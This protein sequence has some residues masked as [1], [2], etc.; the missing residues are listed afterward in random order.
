MD[1]GNPKVTVSSSD[2]AEDR[3]SR[4]ELIGWWNQDILGRAKV[5]VVGAGA[6]GNEILKNLA[7][8]G[9]EHIVV[10]D[11]DI[12][13]MSNLSRSVLFREEDIGR[14]KAEVAAKRV[15]ELYPQCRIKAIAANVMYDVGMGLVGWADVVIGALDNREARLW[16]N[17]SAWKMN[18]PWVDGAIEGINGVV[19]VFMPGCAPCYE[20]TLGERDWDILT[21]RMSC[22]LLTREQME[23]GKTPTTP[24]TS[25]VI[26]GIQVQEA[27]KLLH[28]MPCLAGKG[29]VFEGMNHTS[30]LV[31]YTAND[32]CMSHEVFAD[33]QKWPKTSSDTTLGELM[34]FARSE[35]GSPDVV[36]EFSRDIIWKLKCQKCGGETEVF[37]SAG[38]L[39]MD[40][41]ACPKDGE[42]RDVIT[43]HSYGGQEGLDERTVASLGLPLWDVI[44]IRSN[45]QERHVIIS[46]DMP[47]MQLPE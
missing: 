21:K 13:E 12:I 32:D 39:R 36:L 37:A 38:M 29:F 24:T 4:F 17:R 30:Y 47:S 19:R 34:M 14:S 15:R 1:V 31:E 22:N 28:G 40:D 8:L 46:A 10:I 42:M 18:R 23:G 6:L 43:L 7:L 16:I 27:V 2:L 26:A 9:I 20:C 3:F 45:D 35:L 5:L 41:G 33:V 25:S 44:T 11:M